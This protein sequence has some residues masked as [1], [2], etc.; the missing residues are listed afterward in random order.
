MAERAISERKREAQ[1]LHKALEDTGINLDCVATDTLGESA[2]PRR[3][4]VMSVTL[5]HTQNIG[6]DPSVAVIFQG[7]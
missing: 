7:L 6:Q 5:H 2:R 1:P 4:T 3:Q